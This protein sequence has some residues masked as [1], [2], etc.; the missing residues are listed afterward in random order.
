MSE[1]LPKPQSDA[2]KALQLYMIC[3]R[4]CSD[5]EFMEVFWDFAVGDAL[6]QADGKLSDRSTKGEDL[7]SAR[8]EWVLL[9][10]LLALPTKTV[11]DY[12][13]AQAQAQ[14]E[15]ADQSPPAE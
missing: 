8:A 13:R 2:E 10:D 4:L 3:K 9:Q 11:E 15:K 6:A 14:A 5:R 12:E 7:V 1:P